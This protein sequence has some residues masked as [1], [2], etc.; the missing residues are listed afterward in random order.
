MDKLEMYEKT[1]ELFTQDIKELEHKIDILQLRYMEYPNAS[2][3]IDLTET[4]YDREQAII[5]I[6]RV[7]NK[8][9]ECKEEMGMDPEAEKT[10]VYLQRAH[11]KRS[12]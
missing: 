6:K 3:L 12:L 11:G 9:Q 10:R 5:E 2:T 7:Q 4:K 1:L 8:I